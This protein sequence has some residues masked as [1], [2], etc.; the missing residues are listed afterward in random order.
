MSKILVL[1]PNGKYSEYDT[2]RGDFSHKNISKEEYIEI[3][4]SRAVEE[5]E[6]QLSRIKDSNIAPVL[7]D[8]FPNKVTI[9]SFVEELKMLGFQLGEEHLLFLKKKEEDYQLDAMYYGLNPKNRR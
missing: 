7:N 5:A 1:Q 4:K 2:R 6:L 8:F 3:C 9:E